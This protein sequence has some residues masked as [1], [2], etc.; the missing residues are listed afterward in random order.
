LEAFALFVEE[1]A[2]FVGL[3]VVDD[4]G[5]DGFELRDFGAILPS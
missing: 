4:L 1:A 5:L 3:V 2:F